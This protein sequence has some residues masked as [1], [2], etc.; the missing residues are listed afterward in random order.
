MPDAISLLTSLT[1]PTRTSVAAPA[2]GEGGAPFAALLAAGM[3]VAEAP[4]EPALIPG[5]IPA[6]E[7]ALSPTNKASVPPDGEPPIPPA[8][9]QTPPVVRQPIAAPGKA[10]PVKTGRAPVAEKSPDP[11]PVNEPGPASSPDE[12]EPRAIEQAPLDESSEAPLPLPMAPVV[13]D[14]P[15]EI[16]QADPAPLDVPRALP[17]RASIEP[18]AAPM[19]PPIAIIERPNT[20]PVREIRSVTIAAPTDAASPLPNVVA[21]TMRTPS[22]VVASTPVAPETV[23]V[24]PP[25]I[26]A[27][28]RAP[29]LVAA[30]PPATSEAV[31]VAMFEASEAP[32]TATNRRAPSPVAAP[33]PV[34]QEAT[35][36]L[37]VPSAPTAPGTDRLLRARPNTAFAREEVA[38]TIGAATPAPVEFRAPEQMP[39][40]PIDT[41]AGDWMQS[42]I[43]RIETIT[44]EQGQRETRLKLSPDALGEVE[45]RLRETPDGALVVDM[46]A[47]TPEARALLAEAAPRL[48]EMSEARGL[49]LTMQAGT[50]G[51]GAPSQHREPHRPANDAPIL[52]RRAATGTRDGTTDERVA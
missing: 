37:V 8:T 15:P 48:V 41:Q 7:A 9:A 2:I 12:S 36:S 42:M 35:P 26:A 46:D 34:L 49:R 32:R 17:E 51:D 39:A 33:R 24:A 38:V 16:A 50:Q 45:L 19:T 30:P 27:A 47:V 20:S 6:V 21:N 22:P 11:V 13:R 18:I 40:A 14:D 23:S 5:M 43:E 31:P 1:A 28:I 4:T 52:N 29:L 44:G 10:L 25:V 3:P